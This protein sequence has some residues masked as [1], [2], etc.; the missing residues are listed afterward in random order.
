M[1][2]KY[3]NSTIPNFQDFWMNFFTKSNILVARSKKLR[4]FETILSRLKK[5]HKNLTC[6]FRDYDVTDTVLL[7]L[8]GKPRFARQISLRIIIFVRVRGYWAQ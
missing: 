2:Q 4:V 8:L 6:R 5:Q 1:G 3:A 7:N